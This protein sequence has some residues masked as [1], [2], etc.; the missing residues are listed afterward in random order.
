M[1]QYLRLSHS[2]NA[3]A[4]Q[5]EVALLEA[6][7]WKEHYNKAHYQGEWTVLP[8]RSI[9]GATDNIISVHGANHHHLAYSD[10]ALLHHCPEIKQVL[11]FFNCEKTSVRL[12]KLAAGAIIHEHR[13][14]EMSFEDGE[15]RFHIPIT[16]NK[17]VAFYLEEELIP[18]REGECC[19]LNLSLKHRVQ[20]K[21]TQPRIHLVIDCLVNPW[22]TDLFTKQP[23]LVKYQ[24][25]AKEK[26]ANPEEQARIIQQLRL[27][28]TAVSLKLADKLE[29]ENR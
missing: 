8:L 21:G 11:S 4:L 14:Q 27:M 16:T 9:Q 17:N 2:F 15:V 10:T 12:M 20:N 13:D 22:V 18:M 3:S 26:K 6:A 29:K 5:K 1:I 28:N 24:D 7:F 23:N 25:A 19:Y